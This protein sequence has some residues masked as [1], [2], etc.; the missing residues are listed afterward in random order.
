MWRRSDASVYLKDMKAALIEGNVQM[1]IFILSCTLA[2]SQPSTLFYFSLSGHT[3]MIYCAII[4]HVHYLMNS[5][6]VITSPQPSRPRGSRSLQGRDVMFEALATTVSEAK[7]GMR[8][9]WHRRVVRL[10]CQ[11]DELSDIRTASIQLIIDWFPKDLY[12]NELGWILCQILTF[13]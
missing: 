9:S 8:N 12:L 10:S 13:G 1:S 3:C 4:R 2:V 7:V 11:M 5:K 6:S